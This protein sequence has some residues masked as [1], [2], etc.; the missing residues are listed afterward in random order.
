[1]IRTWAIATALVLATT[2]I[3]NAVH[4]KDRMTRTITQ[5][6]YDMK[7]QANA[8]LDRPTFGE[9]FKSNP[10]HAKYS[11]DRPTAFEIK[12]YSFAKEKFV[13]SKPHVNVGREQSATVGSKQKGPVACDCTNCSA[14]HCQGKPSGGGGGLS[15]INRLIIVTQ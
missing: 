1:M 8:T 5:Y 15:G 6:T 11:K 7:G 9:K 12:D 3:S 4:A 10:V 14:E 2:V 13:R